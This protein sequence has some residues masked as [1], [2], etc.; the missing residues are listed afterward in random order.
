MQRFMELGMERLV[1]RGIAERLNERI[2]GHSGAVCRRGVLAR[3]EQNVAAELSCFFVCFV[4]QSAA[5]F[6]VSWLALLRSDHEKH[7]K[8]R[9]NTTHDLE[10]PR[11]GGHLYRAGVHTGLRVKPLNHNIPEVPEDP[12]VCH[13]HRSL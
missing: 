9:K 5:L 10:F 11:L 8:T 13:D 4:V 1:H 3:N 7:E 2:K 6:P 12:K